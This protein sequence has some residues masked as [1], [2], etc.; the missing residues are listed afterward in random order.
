MHVLPMIVFIVVPLV[1]AGILI[2]LYK[3]SFQELGDDS[4]DDDDGE[5]GEDI[6]YINKGDR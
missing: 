3:K 6:F 2:I 1:I 4:D 5:T